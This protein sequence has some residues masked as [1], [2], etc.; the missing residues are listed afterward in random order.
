[1][2]WILEILKKHGLFVNLKKYHFHKNEVGFLDYVIL[3]E[4]IKME[5]EKIKTVRNRPEPKS[6][7]DIQIFLGFANFYY[8]FI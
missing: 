3:F 2:R 4:D 7:R 1:M 5:D 8:H 6:V